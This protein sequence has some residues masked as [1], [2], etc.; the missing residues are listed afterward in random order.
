MKIKS[1]KL[2]V[3]VSPSRSASTSLRLT[4]DNHPQIAMH[5]ELFGRNKVHGTSK[6]LTAPSQSVRKPGIYHRN[7]HPQKF[8]NQ[9]FPDDKYIYGFNLLLEHW[10]LPANFRFLD[11]LLNNQPNILILWRKNLLDRFRSELLFKFNLGLISLD[12][13]EKISSSDIEANCQKQILMMKRV[14]S[15]LIS[16]PGIRSTIV[17]FEDLISDKSEK[18]I[19]DIQGFIGLKPSALKLSQDIARNKAEENLQ[20]TRII[21]TIFENC[22]CSEYKNYLLD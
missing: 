3:L 19:T 13:L 5:G 10:F 22:G 8:S 17:Y 18:I 20:A 9:F 4:L 2:L 15:E 21:N 14:K 6:K 7:I 1:Q 16:Q 11:A 12:K